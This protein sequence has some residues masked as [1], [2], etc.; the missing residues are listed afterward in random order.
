M[1]CK[2]RCDVQTFAAKSCCVT[3]AEPEGKGNRA[4]LIIVRLSG[5]YIALDLVIKIY[6]EVLFRCFKDCQER[7]AR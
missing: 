4:E 6:A 1:L 2:R 5:S 7:P 3:G